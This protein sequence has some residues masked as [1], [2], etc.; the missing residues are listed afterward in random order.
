MSIVCKLCGKPITATRREILAGTAKKSWLGPHETR[1]RVHTACGEAWIAEQ[2]AK[3]V[4]CG[5]R[6]RGR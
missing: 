3:G 2:Q 1:D 5:I 4:T 6:R